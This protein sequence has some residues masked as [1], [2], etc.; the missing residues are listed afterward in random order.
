MWN[1]RLKSAV[2]IIAFVNLVLFLLEL[3]G[4]F[5]SSTLLKLGA[6][7]G[8][9][10]DSGQYNRLITA[11][12]L[13]GGLLH[14][15][16][17][18]YALIY[19]GTIIEK[20]YSTPK[21]VVAYFLSGVVGNIATQIFYHNT[22][23]IG[24]SG[25]IFGLVGMLFAAGRRRDM[26]YYVRPITGTALLPMIIFN[27]FLGFTAGNINNAA[28]IGGLVTGIV[29]GLAIS[30]RYTW[31][32]WRIWNILMIIVIAVVFLSFFFLFIQ[33]SVSP[34]AIIDFHNSFVSILNRLD[35]GELIS[36]SEVLSL[37]P[38]DGESKKLKNML[39]NHMEEG[40][41]DLNEITDAFL[42]W[43]ERILSDYKGLISVR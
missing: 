8:P 40:Q 4:G 5:S 27:L 12:F 32:G 39:I 11:M 36:F 35:K 9:L 18:M 21:F 20:V 25:A 30:P 29:L 23:S 38:V 22:I 7:Y 37:Q 1:E 15:F 28:H 19:L 6:Q 33:P 3:I 10:V 26:P 14:L 17:N 24:A 42:K 13:H 41:P 43:R 31:R 34:E 16:F 2:F